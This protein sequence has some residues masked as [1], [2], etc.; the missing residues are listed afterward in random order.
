MRKHIHIVACSPRSGTSLLQELMTTCFHVDNYCG[1]EQSIFRS[2]GMTGE[3]VCTK[4]PSEVPYMPWA[5]KVNP[6]LYVIYVLRDPRAVVVS[7]HSKHKQSPDMYYS[8]LGVW[9]NYEAYRK[10]LM[11]HERFLVVRYEDLVSNPDHEQSRINSFL[12]FLDRKCSFSAF[13]EHAAPSESTT[14]AMNGLRPVSTGRLKGWQKHLPRLKAQ[15]ERFGN[16]SDDLVELGYEPNAAWEQ[17][18]EGVVAASYDSVLDKR[19]KS[20]SSLKMKYRIFRKIT[21]Y[22]LERLQGK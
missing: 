6:N 21:V 10:R 2:A 4:N 8:C 18:L 16:I 9:K 20:L 1:H 11:A 3:V 12:P 19:L 17:Q 15:L 7:K 14:V 22:I 13:H 5:L